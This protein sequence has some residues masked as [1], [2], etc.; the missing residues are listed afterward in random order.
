MPENQDCVLFRKNDDDRIYITEGDKEDELLTTKA[1]KAGFSEEQA[2]F[3]E[4]IA[5]L[6]SF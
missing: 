3:L 4:K 2:A 6:L 5:G 1:M